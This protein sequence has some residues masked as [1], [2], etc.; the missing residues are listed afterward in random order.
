MQLEQLGGVLRNALM[1]A[2]AASL[3]AGAVP[4]AAMLPAHAGISGDQVRPGSMGGRNPVSLAATR[5]RQFWRR[6]SVP[7]E[8]LLLAVDA[9][10]HTRKPAAG[11]APLL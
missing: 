7:H 6:K 5:A 8:A 10:L 4:D 3:V 9:L 2:A 1:G 11:I